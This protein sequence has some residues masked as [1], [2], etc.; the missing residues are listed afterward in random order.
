M[1]SQSSA[2][3]ERPCAELAFVPLH[4]HRAEQKQE[5][6]QEQKQKQK[7]KQ[8]KQ[9]SKDLKATPKHFLFLYYFPSLKH[10]REEKRRDWEL[11]RSR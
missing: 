3:G 9:R 4:W 11:K 8:S 1:T 10:R 2:I 5:Q 7:Q 6:E